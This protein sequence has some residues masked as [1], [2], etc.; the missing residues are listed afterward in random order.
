MRIIYFLSHPIQYFTP[1]LQKLSCNVPLFVYYYSDSS[2]RGALDK[3]F[4]RQVKW[5]IPLLEGYDHKFL[6]SLR[7][8]SAPDNQFFSLINPGIFNEIRK[9]DAGVVMVNGWS[10][11]SD[12]LVI[13]SAKL[14]GKRIWLRAENPL[15]QEKNIKGVKKFLKKL[16]LKYILFRFFVDKALYIGSQ[17]KLFFEYYGVRDIDMVYTPYSVDN[18]YF[19]QV[20]QTETPRLSQHKITLKLTGKKII[21]FSGK[22]IPK[23]R[24]LDLIKAFHIANQKDAVLIMVGE[25]ELRNEMENYIKVNNIDNIV[26]TGFVNQRDIPIY[27]LVSDIFVMCS[28]IGETWGLSVN[29]AMNFAKPV[30]ISDTCGSSYDLVRNEVNGY[31]YMEGDIPQ[32]SIYITELLD[33][34]NKRVQMGLESKRIIQNFSNDVIVQNIKNIL[35]A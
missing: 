9:S 33:N 7:N 2:I 23:K 8:K 5:D 19:D 21:L 32:L 6:A 17:N 24:P 29:E 30:I 16:F 10:Y 15:N 18:Y 14:F 35:E 28:G 34:D 20:Y 12:W 1:L 13:I 31:V 27:Y 22:Y 26:L 4:G 11:C 25:G 3:G